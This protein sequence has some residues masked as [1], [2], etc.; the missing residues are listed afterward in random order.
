[1][2]NFITS[3]ICVEIFADGLGISDALVYC[4]KE[5]AT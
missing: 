1:L 4:D 2:K 3:V 5:S